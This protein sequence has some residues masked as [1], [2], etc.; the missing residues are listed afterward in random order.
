M[1]R[2]FKSRHER[3]GW[4]RRL[5][6]VGRLC[7]MHNSP[8]HRCRVQSSNIYYHYIVGLT[9][10]KRTRSRS[11]HGRLGLMVERTTYNTD[12]SRS[13]TPAVF[14]LCSSIYYFEYSMSIAEPI[15]VQGVYLYQLPL[16]VDWT[17]RRSSFVSRPSGSNQLDKEMHISIGQN[18]SS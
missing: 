15:T 6:K 8:T 10:N 9:E 16:T 11:W 12:G 13:V 2:E 17:G 4:W 7:I 14:K 1:S 18:S 3:W 5:R